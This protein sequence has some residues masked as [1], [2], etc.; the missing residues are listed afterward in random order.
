M[1]AACRWLE[2]PGTVSGCSTGSRHR[3]CFPAL[4]GRELLRSAAGPGTRDSA[5]R[6]LAAP[7]WPGAPPG[8]DPRLGCRW[9]FSRT[10]GAVR[11]AAPPSALRG[12]G[13]GRGAGTR[14]RVRGDAGLPS[15][16]AAGAD[17]RLKPVRLAGPLPP[18]APPSPPPP[19]GMTRLVLSL[20]GWAA[21]AASLPAGLSE[22]AAPRLL[23]VPA[24]PRHN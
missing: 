8:T 21:A 15:L 16:D 9:C 11:S 12:E 23:R 10:P 7:P 2:L 18:D 13:S 24:E 17:S 5:A 1:G 20:S 3:R 22:Q 14:P 19:P 6:C 4:S